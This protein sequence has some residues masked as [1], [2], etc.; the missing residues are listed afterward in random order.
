[1]EYDGGNRSFLSFFLSSL[2]KKI[3]SLVKRMMNK[4]NEEFGRK[5]LEDLS[6]REYKNEN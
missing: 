6:W 2:K 1:M 4:I 3:V 5:D